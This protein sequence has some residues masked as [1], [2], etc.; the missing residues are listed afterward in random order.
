MV[1]ETNRCEDCGGDAPV[2]ELLGLSIPAR[3]CDPCEA[4][5]L[6]REEGEQRA[7]LSVEA[8]ERAGATP[9]LLEQSLDTFPGDDPDAL[10]A[11]RDWI[12]RWRAGERRNLW[13]S[14]PLGLGKTGIAWG[15]VR[16]LALTEV[17]AYMD[18]DEEFRGYGPRPVSLFVIWRDLLADLR[19][20]IALGG[21]AA[22]SLFDRARTVPVLALDDLGA[23]RPT[24][25][26]LE[27]LAN[28]VEHR[29]QRR[30]PTVVTSN[31]GTR[32]LAARLG[33]EDPL[34]G[35]RIVDR[36]L[37]GALG[38]RFSGSSRRRAAA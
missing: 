21:D 22:A 2:R 33:Q 18:A 1:D 15:I 19:D 35:E 34:L 7:R 36:L 20:A 8:L 32:D 4:A 12:D 25:Y 5:H 27:Q 38:H 10:R 16:E 29:Y 30:V 23:E 24:A 14:G 11:A 37:E 9:R 28:L 26:A 17:D 13:L 6:E 3:R 31:Y